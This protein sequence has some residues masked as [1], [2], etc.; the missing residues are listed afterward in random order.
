MRVILQ[1]D[2]QNLGEAGDIKDVS[3]GFARNYLLPRKLV[4]LA[5]ED[6]KK[7]HLHQQKLIQIKKEKRKKKQESLLESLSSVEITIPAYSGDEGKL[8]GS[9]TSI[10]IAK[11]LGEIGF[12]VDKRKILLAEPIKQLGDYTVSI[13]LDEGMTAEVKLTVETR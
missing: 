9:V 4:I 1:K 3:K 12:D 8:F 2:I 6:S 13:K 11:K 7:A 10:D 5:S